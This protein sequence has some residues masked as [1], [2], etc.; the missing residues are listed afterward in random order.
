VAQPRTTSA[1][2]K[3][4]GARVRALREEAG[5][6]QEKLAWA[7]DISKPFLSQIEAGLRLP[8]VP[9]LAALAEQLGVQLVDLFVLDLEQPHQAVVE[10]DRLAAGPR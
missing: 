9:V 5:V 2:A 10:A 1:L 7:S 3:S 6:T 8:S 4:I